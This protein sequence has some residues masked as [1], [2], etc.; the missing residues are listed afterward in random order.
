MIYYL[1]FRLKN[2]IKFTSSLNLNS[3][4]IQI[5]DPSKKSNLGI[6]D[7]QSSFQNEA[8]VNINYQSSSEVTVTKRFGK[9]IYHN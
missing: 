9:A 6:I 8:E 2:S 5:E 4:Q 7:L 3:D 1:D